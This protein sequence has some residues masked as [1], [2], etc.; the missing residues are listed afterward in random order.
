MVTFFQSYEEHR[1]LVRILRNLCVLCV[2]I[3]CFR[4]ELST[5]HTGFLTRL[6]RGVPVPVPMKTRTLSAGTGFW[7][8]RV[9]VALK[10]PRVT[11][12]NP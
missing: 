8:V 3:F 2:K 6:T 9:R 7:W 11:R 1:F 4:V 5:R 10:Y 12:D